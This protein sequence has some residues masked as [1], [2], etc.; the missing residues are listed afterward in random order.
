[1]SNIPVN[2]KEIKDYLHLYLPFEYTFY[3][4]K[5]RIDGIVNHGASIGLFAGSLFF[6]EKLADIKLPLRPLS[7]MTEEE[8]RLCDIES[9]PNG[10]AR[11][12]VTHLG[13]QNTLVIGESF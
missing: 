8:G 3:G 12:H 13:K 11:S 9:N 6:I 2:E 10:E 5:Y 7:D 4:I 1:M